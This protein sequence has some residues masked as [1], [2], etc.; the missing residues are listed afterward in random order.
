MSSKIVVVGSCMIDFVSYASRLPTAGE[1]IHGDKF[2]TNFG[3]KGA[4]QCVAAAKLGAD[5]TLVA[6]VGNDIWGE[7][8]IDNLD[9]AGVNTEF[10]LI[11]PNSSS[12]IAQINVAE[13]GENQIVIVAG[14]NKQLSVSDIE[15]A[16]KSISSAEVL[17]M[18]LETPPETAIRAMELCTGISI[19]NGAPA[20]STYD[21]KLL[22]L[23]TIFCIN[24]TEA[25]IFTGLPVNNT[26]DAEKA[27]IDLVTKGCKSVLITLG[28]QGAV[29]H[30]GDCGCKVLKIESPKVKSLD[31]TGAGDAFIG[32]LAY[33]I[34]AKKVSME[35]AIRA[36]CF[37]AADSVTK[38]GTQMSF[39]GPEILKK[40]D[41]L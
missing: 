38:L 8:Y 6:R 27:A 36:A 17:I 14:A 35:K 22:T 40:I 25:S 5:T 15:D 9:S 32:A 26:G 11:T 21:P 29:Y 30:S 1:T 39:P 3:G 28:E 19:L 2:V 7:K 10:V 33:F 12:G 41:F 31:T 34:G 37:V 16:K 20:L 13:S 4:N 24:E 18:Q 23:P